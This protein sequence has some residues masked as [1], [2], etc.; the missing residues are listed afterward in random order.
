MLEPLKKALI[1]YHHRAVHV[2]RAK[3]VAGAL[4]AL[5][6]P[7]G[8]LLDIGCGDGTV[9]KGIAAEI[10]ARVVA[11]VDVLIRPEVA[12][13]VR[14]YDGV[15]LPFPDGA[16]EAVVLADVLHHC[17]EPI[18]VLREALR[19]ASRVVAVKD[20]FCF[21][22]LSDKLLLWMDVIGNAGPGVHVRGTYLSPAEW[23]ALV[24][25]AGGHLTG[26]DWPLRIHD[27]PFRLITRSELQFAARI[28]R[29]FHTR[30]ELTNGAPHGTTKVGAR[31]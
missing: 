16:F 19:V 10:G 6:G 2:P 4:A 23:I 20:H 18:T 7:A 22:P 17:A 14:P 24:R 8:S 29:S 21:G 26:L 27:F 3:R 30:Y 11:G 13:D 9:A 12:I 31:S 1:A 15:H 5:I 28:E 25:D